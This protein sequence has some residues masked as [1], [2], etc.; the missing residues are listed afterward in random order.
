MREFGENVPNFGGDFM[1]KM[2]WIS[3]KLAGKED[4]P[5]AN[6]YRGRAA[7]FCV[8]TVAGVNLL[9]RSFD[10]GFSP[11]AS[12]LSVIHYCVQDRINYIHK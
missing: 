1:K 12:F 4:V 8:S 11:A 6:Y 10:A 3:E 5:W 7:I 2:R 9:K